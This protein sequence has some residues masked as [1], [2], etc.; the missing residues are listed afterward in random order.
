MNRILSDL[1]V[2]IGE[3]IVKARKSLRLSQIDLSNAC[4]ISQANISLIERGKA[5]PS[6]LTLSRI[7]AALKKVIYVNFGDANIEEDAYDR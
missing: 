4:G 6:L 7:A 2:S 3:E 5:N 1:A